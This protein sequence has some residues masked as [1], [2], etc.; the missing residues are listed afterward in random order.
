[1]QSHFSF[2]KS[3]KGKSVQYSDLSEAQNIKFLYLNIRNKSYIIRPQNKLSSSRPGTS[4]NV[5]PGKYNPREQRKVEVHEFSEVPRFDKDRIEFMLKKTPSKAKI[6]TINRTDSSRDFILAYEKTKFRK[7]PAKIQKIKAEIVKVTKANIDLL[8]KEQKEVKLKEKF[9]KLEY[10][11]RISEIAE[12]KKAWLGIFCTFG[13]GFDV[14][15]FLKNRKR[16]R[17]RIFKQ[18]G[19]LSMIIL[20]VGKVLSKVKVYRR[21]KAFRVRIR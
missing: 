6:S 20:A 15:R 8:A 5:G 19:R 17:M 4:H 11:R 10:R 18:V 16:L 2:S 13:V 9:K 7:K 12:I 21:R 1:M 14:Y 3:R